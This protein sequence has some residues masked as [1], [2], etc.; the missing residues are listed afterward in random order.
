M[1]TG[2]GKSGMAALLVAAGAMI[3]LCVWLLLPQTQ[4][5]MPAPTGSAQMTAAA[6]VGAAGQ[7]A[8]KV[9]AA[10]NEQPSP[11]NTEAK[12]AQGEPAQSVAA[13]QG[14]PAQAKAT[15]QG[16][17]PIGL[18]ASATPLAAIVASNA[19]L[20]TAMPA[21]DQTAAGNVS[22]MTSDTQSNAAG[23]TVA[24]PDSDLIP[25]TA[26]VST[27][28]ASAAVTAVA[29]GVT[30][31]GT[32]QVAF[33]TVE[34]A[35]AIDAATVSIGTAI[36]PQP[37]GA[38]PAQASAAALATDVPFQ[39]KLDAIFKRYQTMGAVVCVIENGGITDTFTYGNLD[40]AGTPITADTLFRVGSISKMVTA[41][42]IMHLVDEGKATLD[43]DVSTLLG[44][45][46]RN[47]QHPD[48]P[49]TLRQMM[50]HT[51][52]LRDSAQYTKALRGEIASLATLFST[53]AVNL[54]FLSNA[55]A[56][57][58]TEYSNF[59]GGLLGSIIESVT[60]QTVDAY[61]QEAIFAPLGITAAYQSALLP[62]AATVTDMFDMPRQ[63]VAATVRDGAAASTTPSP[64]TD[65]TLT[66]GKL[67]LSAVDLA[68]LVIALCDGGVYENTRVLTDGSAVAMRT[69][70]NGIGSVVCDSG[71]GLCM[72]ILTEKIVAG[73][74]LY[75]HGGKANGMLC[76]A[77]FDPVDRTGVVML[78][79]GC[80]NAPMFEDVGTLSVMVMRLCYTQLI[81][82]RHVTKDLWLVEE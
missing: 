1:R 70:Q 66:A 67:T 36:T 19:G 75:G 8:G 26:P 29:R 12:P 72:N 45:P 65:Y 81:D 7:A 62:A 16:T 68:K 54:M 15:L 38:S 5:A 42:G 20:V 55:Q 51:A 69:P 50:S 52:G 23:A 60:G 17:V 58:K 32:T 11:Q 10:P 49:I 73:H 18:Q 46:V 9:T 37:T 6:T 4:V 71:R 76:A 78:T 33:A 63:A 74:T 43:G 79:N 28:T 61:M 48:T 56:G 77:Y 44:I 21:T 47:A 13:P 31:D 82:P 35:S 57:H 30:P 14:T 80:N 24:T 2:A 25:A 27:V 53:P 3:A 64:W 34:K 41:M 40:Q 22:A 39:Q 59:G